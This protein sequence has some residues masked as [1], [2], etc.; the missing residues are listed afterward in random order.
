MH[1]H[2]PTHLAHLACTCACQQ[3]P[4][5]SRR[6]PFA[7]VESKLV[8]LN[9]RAERADVILIQFWRQP[10]RRCCRAGRCPARHRRRRRNFHCIACRSHSNCAQGESAHKS[11]LS[12]DSNARRLAQTL[13]SVKR[14]RQLNRHHRR[15]P[16]RRDDLHDDND[17]GTAEVICLAGRRRAPLGAGANLRA[18][19][20]VFLH[21]KVGLLNGGGRAR[22]MPPRQRGR[23]I[24]LP[25]SAGT[26]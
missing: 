2:T 24:A 26:T 21:G 10:R 23:E 8:T 15:R 19:Q 14:A 20:V 13:R 3:A 25:E 9:T 4:L 22:Y 11:P 17:D 6:R 1:T 7:P 16:A 12:S 18:T 5:C